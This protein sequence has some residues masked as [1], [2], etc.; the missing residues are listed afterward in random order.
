MRSPTGEEEINAV[1]VE[2]QLWGSMPMGRAVGDDSV[3][4]IGNRCIVGS[5]PIF[6]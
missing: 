3:K 1:G 5:T 6:P 4:T 2:F